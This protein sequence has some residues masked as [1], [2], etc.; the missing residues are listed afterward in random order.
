MLVCI[1]AWFGLLFNLWILHLLVENGHAGCRASTSHDTT[2]LSTPATTQMNIHN[3]TAVSSQSQ[4][5][6]EELPTTMPTPSTLV[7]SEVS[8]CQKSQQNNVEDG[9]AIQYSREDSRSRDINIELGEMIALDNRPLSNVEN[10]GFKNL[11]RKLKPNY[12][13]R[14]GTYF[15]E[16]AIPQLYE[17][18]KSEIRRGVCRGSAMTGDDDEGPKTSVSPRAGEGARFAQRLMHTHTI[19]F[20]IPKFTVCTRIAP[21][22]LQSFKT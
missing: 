3:T 5:Q 10:T 17:E 11:M 21:R 7:S 22:G 9:F 16:N 20:C 15:T 18:T 2:L 8:L 6:A 1:G 4:I 19:F 12:N 13:I 14:G